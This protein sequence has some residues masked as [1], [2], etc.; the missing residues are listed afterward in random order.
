MGQFFQASQTA[1]GL[2]LRRYRDEPLLRAGNDRLSA[3]KERISAKLVVADGYL[4][5]LHQK[6]DSFRA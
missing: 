5:S 1:N 4:I 2:A 6:P 3:I